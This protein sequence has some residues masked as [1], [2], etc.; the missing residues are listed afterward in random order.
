MT[1][2]QFGNSNDVFDASGADIPASH[3]SAN[4]NNNQG[5]EVIFDFHFG[6]KRDIAL[7]FK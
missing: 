6:S 5:S 4:L 1:A 3:T 7:A 2:A